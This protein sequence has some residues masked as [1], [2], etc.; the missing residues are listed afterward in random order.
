MSGNFEYRWSYSVQFQNLRLL[1]ETSQNPLW[2]I[3]SD[4]AQIHRTVFITIILRFSSKS[5][6]DSQNLF[7]FQDCHQ[8]PHC[9]QNPIKNFIGI[10]SILPSESFQVSQDSHQ[11]TVR[12]LIIIL[13][14]NPTQIKILIRIPSEFLLQSFRDYCPN[15]LG[16]SSEY[17]Q[18]THRNFPSI[19]IRIFPRSSSFLF[20]ELYRNLSRILIRILLGV[21]SGSFQESHQ[22][23]SRILIRILQGLPSCLPRFAL[24]FLQE[25][26]QTLLGFEE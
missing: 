23:T 2:I 16:S 18:D 25:S 8:K 10:L 24:D 3:W 4:F 14:Y 20:Q 7:S 11:N 6:Y 22:N 17:S 19:L 13:S 21:S 9:H 1:S 5:S 26:H 12:I 15:P